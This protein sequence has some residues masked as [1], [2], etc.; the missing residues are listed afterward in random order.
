MSG[1]GSAAD[2]VTIANQAIGHTKLGSSVAG[3]DQAAGRILEADGAGDMRWA[4]KGGGGGGGGDD[5]VADSLEVDITG[6]TLTV[7]VGRSGTL[8]DLEDTAT[9]PDPVSIASLPTQDSPL[10]GSDLLGIWDSSDGQVEKVPL[11]VARNFMQDDLDADEVDVDATGFGDN[12]ATTDT[13]VQLVAQAVNDLALVEL[14]DDAPED[15]GAVAD[16]GDGIAASKY[17]HSHRLPTDNTLEFDG[18]A[19]LG[20]NIHDVIEHLQERIRYYTAASDYSSSAGASVG[21]IYNTSQYDKVITKVEA[22]FNPLGGADEYLVRL[23]DTNDDNSI[24]AKI[25]VSNTRSTAG[26]T[27]GVRAFNFHDGA[28]EVGVRID[29]GIR[30]GILLSRL[31]DNSDSATQAVHGSEAGNSP[32]ESYGDASIDFDLVNDVVYQH[33]DPAVNASTHSHGTDIRGNLKIFYTLIIDHGSLVGDGNVN[34]AHIDSETADD[35]DVL[36]ADGSGA[37]TWET[38]SGGGGGGGATDAED[39][40]VDTTNFDG[41][42][43]AADDD[44]QAALETIDSFSQYQGAWQQASWPAGV[45]VTRSGIAYISLVNSNTQI[46][47]PASTQWAGLTEGFTYRG[48]APILATNYNYGHVVKNPDTGSYY[49][50]TSTI[51]ASVARADIATHANFQAIGGGAITQATETTLGG[52]QGASALQAISSSGTDILGWTVNRLQQLLSVSLPTMAQ[53][54]ID[55]A[56]T[57]RKAV[58]GALIAANA[59]GG[60]GTTPDRIVLADAVAVANTAG[61]H[62]IALTEA[63]VARQWVSFFMFTTAGASPD[64]IGYLLSDD[65]LALTA[66]ATT[67]TDAENALPVVTASYSAS[68]FSQQSGNYFVYRKDDSTLWVR[69][70][71]L[72]AHTLTVTATPMGGGLTTSRATRRS[73]TPRCS[74]RMTSPAPARR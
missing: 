25:A 72:A 64:G 62:E 43:T 41:N 22:L 69:A 55:D 59:G 39:V 29:G 45:I 21:Q 49:Y 5:G 12:L 2:P 23:V 38:P 57:G 54:D 67:P 73:A 63:M 40:A 17:N 19:Q 60:G 51:S 16:D 33:I 4:D 15:I 74:S 70:T 31:G 9:I 35:G 7:T 68:N 3:T 48:E 24:K 11:T 65:I 20:V 52:V 26:G 30:L 50:F 1:D 47:T 37:A 53:S 27:A 46:P 44:V 36:T 42:L 34:A 13:D 71:R 28:G 66:E 61:P 14:S 18:S 32:G 56:T 8:V 6:Q 58:T 10:D